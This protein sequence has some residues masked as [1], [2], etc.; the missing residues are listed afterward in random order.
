MNRGGMDNLGPD[1]KPRAAFDMRHTGMAG[2]PKRSA[3]R[4]AQAASWMCAALYAA[5]ALAAMWRAPRV[6]YADGWGFL[7]RFA[8]A[9]GFGAILRTDNGHHEVLP[10]ALRMLELRIFDAQQWLQVGTGIV[11]LLATLAV[12]WSILRNEAAAEKRAAAMLVAVLGLC[13]LGNIRILGHANETVH[14]YLVT[15]CVVLGIAVLAPA[16]GQAPGTR[17]AAVAAALGVVAAFSFGTGLAAFVAFLAV[18][19]LRRARAGVHLVLAAAFIGTLALRRWGNAGVEAAVLQF[20]PL[21]QLEHLLRWLATPSVY[22]VWPLADPALAARIP[23]SPIRAIAEPVAAAWHAVFGPVMLARWPHLLT[24][25][26]GSCWLGAATWR[27]RTGASPAGLLGLGLAWFGLAVGGLVAVARL[28]Y[29]DLHPDQLLASRYVVWSSLFWSGLGVAAVARA[30]RLRIALPVVLVVAAG[31][32][33]SQAWMWRFGAGMRAVADR[34][35]V[36]AA[37]GVLDPALDLGETDPDQLAHVLPAIRAAGATVFAWPE[38]ASLGHA[39]P[40]GAPGSVAAGP[41]AIDVV[42]N[43]LGAP[44]RRVRFEAQADAARLLLVDADGVARGI[45]I[46]D[47]DQG[48]WLGWM[49]GTGGGR[50]RAVPLR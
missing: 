5:L 36:A 15:L 31:L 32:L 46:R 39:L 2:S 19:W 6:P 42:P 24:G 48:G 44:G 30:S 47:P 21:S 14:A 11:L 43:R 23:V 1:K 8:S 18:A 22:A 13:W 3:V 29:F 40:D 9:P 25:I 28:R 27:A 4:W 50:V 12:M 26:L 34:T 38:T 41:M 7:G 10:H 35:A 49:R 45:A 33:P 37:V 16:R 17:A 20:A